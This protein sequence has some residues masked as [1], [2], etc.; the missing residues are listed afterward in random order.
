LAVADKGKHGFSN[1]KAITEGWSFWNGSSKL[2][3][4][5]TRQRIAGL[6]AQLLP[7]KKRPFHTIIPAGD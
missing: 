3:F 5:V 1:S 7:E 6:E 4:Y 2:S